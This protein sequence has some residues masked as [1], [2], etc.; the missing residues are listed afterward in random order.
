M[1]ELLAAVDA[2]DIEAVKGFLDAGVDI[3][4]K[5]A[6]GVTALMHA[7]DLYDKKGAADIAVLL[8]DE[9]ADLDRRDKDCDTALL[10]A[11]RNNHD[12]KSRIVDKLMEKKAA[13][14]VRG[15]NGHT[16]LSHA[17]YAGL[18]RADVI[19]EL[20]RR[21]ADPESVDDDSNTPLRLA[22]CGGTEGVLRE[23]IV[24]RDRAA[25]RA[26]HEAVLSAQQAL[27]KAA[28]QFKLR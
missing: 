18:D 10:H 23:A 9:G 25:A 16:P 19:K 5:D 8:I 26:N 7:I 13:V 12:T 6:N 14:N 11:C 17:V 21:G 20:V 24:A 2:C 15:R 1:A 3:N 27:R 22:S 4:E 28:P